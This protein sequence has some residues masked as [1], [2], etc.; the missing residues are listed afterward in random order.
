MIR[1]V[2]AAIGKVGI[3]TNFS[4]QKTEVMLHLYGPGS[5][6]LRR[7]WL[8]SDCPKLEVE[9]C[10]GEAVQVSLTDRYVHLGSVVH[11]SGCDFL[12]VQRRRTLA[13]IA[14]AP[15]KSRLLRNPFLSTQEKLRAVD[16]IPLRK[17]LVGAGAWA[18]A[19]RQEQQAYEATYTGFMRQTCDAITGFSGAGLTN[20]QVC[21]LMG[22]LEPADAMTAET[23]RYLYQALRNDKGYYLTECGYVRFPVLKLLPMHVG[24]SCRSLMLTTQMRLSPFFGVLLARLVICAELCV[25]SA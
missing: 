20:G 21:S 2:E 25:D 6:A 13:Q 8:S 4:Q 3:R 14:F 16:R 24:L 22:V 9:L 11:F 5:Q 1:H 18:L 10:S 15:V 17:F 23:V 12:D 7:Q 19:T